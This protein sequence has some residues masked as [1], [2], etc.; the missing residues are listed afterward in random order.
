MSS[1]KHIRETMISEYKERS[2]P[3]RERLSSWSKEPPITIAHRPTNLARARTLG[4]RAKQGV[5]V[6]RVRLSKGSSKRRTPSGGRKPSRS[7][8]YFTRAKSMQA[9]A[10]ERAARKFS[11]YEVLNS[12]YVGETGTRNYF[13]IIMLD[14]N[15]SSI[16]NDPFYSMVISRRSRAFRGVTAQGRK[17]RGLIVK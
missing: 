7:G 1:Y 8:R 15:S 6:V 10:E 9:I 16:R 5:A 3:Y 2:L 12:Y 14:R 17:H 13:E 4:Y 11:N